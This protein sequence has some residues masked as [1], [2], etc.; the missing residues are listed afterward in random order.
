[1][2]FEEISKLKLYQKKGDCEDTSFLLASLLLALGLDIRGV[3]VVLGISYEWWDILKI[4]A[5]GHAWVEFYS[6][7][8][9][10]WDL[11]ESTSDSEFSRFKQRQDFLSWTKYQ[12]EILVYKD[13][14][15]RELDRRIYKKFPLYY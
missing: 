9:G 7:T 15:E 4:W 1:M 3:R 2:H 11:L 8:R 6:E 14:C 5:G 10:V 13:W 12:A